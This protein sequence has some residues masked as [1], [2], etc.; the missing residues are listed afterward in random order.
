MH[1]INQ[2]RENP[3]AFDRALQQRNAE[4]AAQ[5]LIARDDA[6]RA[7]IAKAQALQTTRNDA[8]KKIG[9]AKGAG[10]DALA[11]DLMAQIADLKASL[12]AQQKGWL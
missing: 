11:E 2:V 9:Q 8:S 10:D 1:D 5:S 3:E 4:P 12:R 7:A 6:R